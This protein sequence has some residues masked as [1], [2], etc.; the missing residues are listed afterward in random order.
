MTN[1]PG[2][3]KMIAS[4]KGPAHKNEAPTNPGASLN[5]GRELAGRTAVPRKHAAHAPGNAGTGPLRR[6]LLNLHLASRDD[7]I[8]VFGSH[9]HPRPVGQGRGRD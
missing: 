8:G 3:L 5:K 4:S 6:Q 2:V 1:F 9:L 7:T